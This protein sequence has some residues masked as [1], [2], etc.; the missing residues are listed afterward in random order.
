MMCS[1]NENQVTLSDPEYFRQLTIRRGGG[2]KAHCPPPL[3]SRKPHNKQYHS[4]NRLHI[5]RLHCHDGVRPRKK[6][7]YHCYFIMKCR[8]NIPRW[9]LRYCLGGGGLSGE[10]GVCP[11]GFVR[12]VLSGGF[13][14]GGFVRGQG[15]SWGF[16]RGGLSRGFCLG[17]FVQGRFVQ[18]GF[19]PGGFCRRILSGGGGL[20]R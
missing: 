5:L 15:L 6:T 9:L 19:V 20:S 3:R 10:G 13:I 7:F 4:G 12:G 16:V 14:L 2:L 18:G 17:G 11:G 1:N 8:I